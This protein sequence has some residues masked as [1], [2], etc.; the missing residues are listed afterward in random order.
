MI[1]VGNSYRVKEEGTEW[2]RNLYR[3]MHNVARKCKQSDGKK[4]RKRKETLR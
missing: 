4:L 3:V 2:F 1:I